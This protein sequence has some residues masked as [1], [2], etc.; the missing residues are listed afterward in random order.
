[1]RG[2]RNALHLICGASTGALRRPSKPL[3]SYDPHYAQT[4]GVTSPTFQ[5]PSQTFIDRASIYINR[6]SDG[7]DLQRVMIIT[8]C[9]QPQL[10]TGFIPN[11]K[12]L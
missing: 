3:F 1:M 12:P 8:G 11:K 9:P 6:Q 5:T 7:R 10:Y 2:C 4:F